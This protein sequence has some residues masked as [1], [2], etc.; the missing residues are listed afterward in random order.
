MDSERLLKLVANNIKP[1]AKMSQQWHLVD[2]NAMYIIEKT[3]ELRL[4]PARGTICPFCR[5]TPII[6]DHPDAM[7]YGTFFSAAGTIGWAL[8]QYRIQEST[9]D[10][11]CQEFIQVFNK[12]VAKTPTPPATAEE[13]IARDRIIRNFVTGIGGFELPPVESVVAHLIE[14]GFFCRQ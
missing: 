13:F 8:V 5:D 2:F 12:I 7:N 6:Y 4:H 9:F 10:E 3:K 1:T 14:S 11:Q